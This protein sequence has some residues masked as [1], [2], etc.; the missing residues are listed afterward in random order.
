MRTFVLTEHT[1]AVLRGYQLSFSLPGFAWWEP[2]FGNLRQNSAGVTHGVAFAMTRANRDRMCDLEGLMGY[3]LRDVTLEAYDGR[4]LRAFIFILVEGAVERM[5][6]TRY[7][8]ILC[9]GAQEAG[10]KAE[11]IEFLSKQSCFKTSE[12][13]LRLRAK[14]R[15]HPRQLKAVSTTELLSQ[16]EGNWMSLYGYVFRLGKVHPFFKQLLG[17]DM[18]SFMLR[19]IRG[20]PLMDSDNITWVATDNKNDKH[21]FQDLKITGMRFLPRMI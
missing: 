15:P 18:T 21:S 19:L 8:N 4:S 1:P 5:P 13:M 10:L 17:R 14:L 16:K 2:A 7:L 12:V 6:S 9:K 20:E 3:E 11:Y